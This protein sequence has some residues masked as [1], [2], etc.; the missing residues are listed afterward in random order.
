MLAPLSHTLEQFSTP[1]STR[2]L[3]GQ[4][5]FLLSCLNYFLEKYFAL[6]SRQCTHVQRFSTLSVNSGSL[7][8]TENSAMEHG[9]FGEQ[10]PSPTLV[11]CSDDQLSQYSLIRL[12]GTLNLRDLR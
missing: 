12:L 3:E 4:E 8:A 9:M 1:L 5:P 2:I 11:Q 6:R 7:N 10:P